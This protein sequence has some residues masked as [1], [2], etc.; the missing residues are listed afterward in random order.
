MYFC[1]RCRNF[2]QFE[3]DY[4]E[5]ANERHRLW[6]KAQVDEEGQVEDQ[7]QE[8]SEY[9]DTD[10]TYDFELTGDVKCAHCHND[11]EDIEEDEWVRL[12]GDP[13][14]GGPQSNPTAQAEKK[15]VENLMM[16]KKQIMGGK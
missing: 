2:T 11:V 5:Y 1:R 15:K 9:C 7:T 14:Y 10:D 8:D 12:G 6:G 3:Q 4:E 13:G 16:L